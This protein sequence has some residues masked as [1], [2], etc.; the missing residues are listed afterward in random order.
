MPKPSAPSMSFAL[1]AETSTSAESPESEERF[2]MQFR[3]L[4]SSRSR[5]RARWSAARSRESWR[6]R[7]ER[8]PGCFFRCV[9]SGHAGG[10]RTT[11]LAMRFANLFVFV[12]R[13]TPIRPVTAAA[14]SLSPANAETGLRRNPDSP[15]LDRRARVWIVGQKRRTVEVRVVE[16]R[17]EVRG[18]GDAEA[19]LDHAPRH[20][21]QPM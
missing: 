3:V 9:T 15:T 5:T 1:T 10:E 8:E 4:P 18:R 16:Q 13:A 2:D 14:I 6:Y 21:E 7:F 17:G 12:E 20:H 19:R 11:F